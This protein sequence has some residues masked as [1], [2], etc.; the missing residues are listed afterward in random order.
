[1][2]SEPGAEGKK[3]KDPEKRQDPGR[4]EKMAGRVRIK[5]CGLMRPEDILYVNRVQPDF[6][7]F[8]LAEG[9]KRTLNREQ[10]KELASGL[11][12][13]ILKTGVFV[14]Q[15]PGWIADTV[16]LTG[17]DAVQLHGDETEKEI[18]KLRE[19]LDLGA[20]RNCRIVRAYRVEGPDDIRRAEESCA[21]L[22]L[23]DHGAGGSGKA[24]DWSLAGQLKRFF[25][26]A[27]GLNAEN[28][29]EAIR[30]V[31]PW[32]VDVSSGV[33]TRGKKDPEKIKKFVEAVRNCTG[34]L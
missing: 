26:L 4:S 10:A 15:D 9:R 33:E 1:M 2:T 7:G 5:I 11:A 31:K 13:G 24:F 21:D 23:L 18:F 27:G 29:A 16:R 30:R 34:V 3:R 14:N 20:G 32:A 6:A 12:P 25:F 17:L 22:V 19:L 8:I 28:A